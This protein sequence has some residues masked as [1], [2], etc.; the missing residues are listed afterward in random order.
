[1]STT[2]IRGSQILDESLT[3][4]DIVY[5]LDDAYDNSGAG[6]GRTITADSGPI[7]V[8]AMTGTFLLASGTMEVHG[9]AT[10]ETAIRITR[11]NIEIA[12]EAIIGT[13]VYVS[14]GSSGLS[15]KDQFGSRTLTEL[16]TPAKVSPLHLYGNGSDGD[17]T[18]TSNFT[19]TRE[20]NFQNLIINAGGAL[21]PNGFRIFVRNL[22]T[23]NASG[24]IN[25]NGNDASGVTAGIALGG[26]NFLDGR[27]GPGGAGRDGVTSV[28]NTGGGP[29]ANRT[30]RNAVGIV[31]IGGKG[32][33]APGNAGGTGGA[34]GPNGGAQW[35]SSWMGGIYTPNAGWYG[36]S[37][38]G[39]GGCNVTGG[40]A[41]SGA[42]GSGAGIVWIAAANIVNSGS[43]SANGGKGSDASST[44]G[45][46][47]GGGGGG[48]GFVCLVTNTP[49]TECGVVQCNGGSGGKGAGTGATDGSE[50]VAG[51]P[52]IF[53]YGDPV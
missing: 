16:R 14:S 13:N 1:M 50:G 9:P 24:S 11:G 5:S 46:A 20:F 29:G 18:I 10:K 48:G 36:S 40:S 35:G 7:V 45:V 12:G 28:G 31:P 26:R 15:L 6:L 3:S 42:G 4:N 19:A 51:Y 22:L 8:N 47:G 38:G 17:M 39:G 34:L 33:D 27:S 32:G 52:L 53:S 30:P 23:I 2:Q 49:S 43:I 25:D 21:K 44:G 41:K 37:G